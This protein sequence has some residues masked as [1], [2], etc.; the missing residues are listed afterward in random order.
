VEELLD[1]LLGECIEVEFAIGDS[2]LES[3]NVFDA[4]EARKV[5]HI[6]AWRRVKGRENPPDVLTVKDRIDVEGSEWKRV[7]Y[8]RMRA[9]SEDLNGRVKKRIAYSQFTWQGL[10]NTSIHVCLIQHRLRRSD[11]RRPHRQARATVQHIPL[12]LRRSPG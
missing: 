3:Q 5:D 1:R 4:L 7:V 11:S 8:K 12:R 6:I 10:D 9:M 2:Q